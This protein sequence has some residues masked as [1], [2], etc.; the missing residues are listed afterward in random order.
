MILRINDVVSRSRPRDS[1]PP[2]EPEPILSDD[3]EPIGAGLPPPPPH[4]TTTT[5]FRPPP[6]PTSGTGRDHPKVT[7]RSRADDPEQ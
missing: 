1:G 5:T 6:L 2:L 3:S 7:G 4:G